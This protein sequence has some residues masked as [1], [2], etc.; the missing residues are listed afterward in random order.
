M[1]TPELACLDFQ[2]CRDLPANTLVA[3]LAVLR[4]I[5]CALGLTRLNLL[6]GNQEAVLV[7][8]DLYEAFH[9]WEQHQ[10]EITPDEQDE[11]GDSDLSLLN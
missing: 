1:F 8:S 2:E 6:V 7:S 10:T 5:R 4:E 9:A 3:P 11:Q